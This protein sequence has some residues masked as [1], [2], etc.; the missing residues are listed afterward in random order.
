MQRP[1]HRVLLPL[2]AALAAPLGARP[3]SATGDWPHWRGPSYDGSTEAEGLPATF[4]REENVAW[5]VALPGSGASTPIVCAGRVFLTSIEPEGGHLLALCL[6]AA[7]GEILWEDAAGSGYRPGGSGSTVKLHDRSN[8]ASPSAACDGERVVFFFGNGDLVA[9]D[10][11]GERL[12]ARN[13][14]KDL[15]DFAFQWTFSA[16]PTIHRGL[17]VLPILQRDEPANGLGREGAE[18]FLLAMDVTSGETRYRVVRPSDAQMESLESYA[19]AIPWS[20]SGRDELIVVGGDVITG[21]EATTGKELWRW[22]TWNEGHRE[23][24]WRVVPSPV[25]GGG[26]VLACAPKRA[27]VYA[28]RLGGEGDLGPEGL[29]WHSDGRRNPVSSDVPTPLYYRERFFVLS[30]V[31]EALSRVHPATG[32]VEWTVSLPGRH[33]WR[34]SP[35]GA[36]GRIWFMNHGGLLLAVDP[37]SGKILHQAEMAGPDEDGIRSSIAVADS[38]L[39]VRTNDT[40]YCLARQGE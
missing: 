18:S 11:E 7:T 40:L 35:T 32:E 29:V 33:R 37:D 17:V 10:L 1:L 13:L 25:V 16:S 27:P 30:D 5:S 28:I 22:G 26:V 20:G 36:D 23:I 4:G 2:L 24:W 3:T 14:Q 8:Y 6:D 34:G 15:G 39:Y 31:Q 38:R 19:T 12:W 21:H 9:Y